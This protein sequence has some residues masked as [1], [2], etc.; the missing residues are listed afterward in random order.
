MAVTMTSLVS[1]K[2][3]A[4][5][6]DTD[7]ETKEA[8]HE[9]NI[10]DLRS[11]GTA[12]SQINLIY[13]DLDLSLAGAPS[14]IDLQSF[15][16]SFGVAAKSFAL[17]Y[18]LMIHNKDTTN[19][20]EVGEAGANAWEAFVNTAGDSVVVPANGWLI[21]GNTTGATVDATHKNLQLDPGANTVAVELLILGK[22][23]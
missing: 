13:S 1:M 19:P 22:S 7:A 18:W 2:A 9:L 3:K 14:T 5:H 11:Y 4:Y 15:T 8:T 6:R 16:D 21:W 20:I 12:T 17:V 10:D 23:S